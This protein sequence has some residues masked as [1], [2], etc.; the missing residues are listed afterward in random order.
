MQL[1]DIRIEQF[2]ALRDL[3]LDNL[4]PRLT[5]VYGPAGCGKSTFVS[6]LRGMLFGLSRQN[7]EV[8]GFGSPRSTPD[9]GSL[10]VQISMGTGM[11]RRTASLGGSETFSFHDESGRSV[12][13]ESS[14]GLSETLLPGWVTEDVFR[15]VCS[16]G[17]TEATRFDLLTRLCTALGHEGH[18]A[19][20]EVRRTETALQQAVRDRDGN[21]IQGGVVHRISELRRRQGELQGEIT[22]LRRP[23]HD[24]QLRIE[25]LVRE[26]EL[27][28]ATI[29]RMDSRLQGIDSEL[30]R[31]ERLL[32]DLQVCNV[33]PLNRHDLDSDIQNLTSRLER[34]REIRGMI[35]REAESHA[36]VMETR[37][38]V[39]DSVRSVRALIG[40]LEE[41]MQTLSDQNSA[42][43]P[44]SESLVNT[45]VLRQLKSETA[46]LCQYFGEHERQILQAADYSRMLWM[47]RCLADATQLE[48]VLESQLMSLQ[49]EAGRAGNILAAGAVPEAV[50]ECQFS[51]HH[52][53][54]LSDLLTAAGFRTI[55]DVEAELVRLRAERSRLTADRTETE[56]DRIAKRSLL[57]KLR[58]ELSA[59]GSLEQLD[60]LRAQIAEIDAEVS[61]LEDHRRHLDRA[62]SSLREVIERLKTRR[63]SHLFE[64]A[65]EYAVRLTE[66]ECVR[67]EAFGQDRLLV[68]L[69]HHAD[70]RPMYQLSRSSQDMIGL[71]LRLALLQTHRTTSGHVPLILDDYFGAVDSRT[72]V[73]AQLLQEISTQGQQILVVTSRTAVKDLFAGLH[74]DVRMFPVRAE[75]V[76]QVMAPPQI[77]QTQPVMVKLET[78]PMPPEPEREEV[79]SLEPVMVPSVTNWLF[80]LEVDHG[81]EDLAGITLGELEGLRSAGVLTVND[82]LCRTV[83]QLEELVRHKGFLIS[84]DRLQAL[85]GQAELA[86]RV[87]MLRRSDASLL[88]ASGIRSA[89]ELSRLRPE[90][91][92]DRVTAFQRTDAGTRFRRGGRLIDRQQAINWARFGQFTRTLEDA[93]HSRSRFGV[94]AKPRLL[95]ATGLESISSQSLS[96]DESAEDNSGRKRRR[97]RLSGDGSSEDRRA[98]RQARRR[99]QVSRLRADT[100]T[101]GA[102][103]GI[104]VER[105]GGMRFFLSRSSEVEKAPSIGPR[106]ARMLEAIGIRTVEELLSIS[107]DRVAEK[108]NHRRITAE[109]IRQWQSQASL[110]CQIPELRGHDAQILV[111]CGISTPEVLAS[112]DANELFAVVEPFARTKEGERILRS[113]SQPDLA[114]VT[115]WIQWAANARTLRAA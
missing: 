22:Q 95:A 2:G 63:W 108:L 109:V 15:E 94:R 93:Q 41:R 71:A 91:V 114:E 40:R 32:A 8:P 5:V 103:E 58:L 77:P 65:S 87:P 21:G 79:V 1:T 39:H 90:T 61:L 62:E 80:Y 24:L 9:S 102:D 55:E 75:A 78:P 105:V 99:Q 96:T 115:E 28:T 112:H 106:T 89:E 104:P 36:L 43:L 67:I 29:A 14:R 101:D 73:A 82:L 84:V 76:T 16:P 25:Q 100:P 13:D 56:Q 57:E 47:E 19:E 3:A 45:E 66:G 98:R 64:V 4:S 86:V 33:L 17:A 31:L 69:R 52:Q 81:M 27:A 42:T 38:T 49:T 11:V 6:F 30:V 12:V 92:Y 26:I 59:G 110:L 44:H 111:A 50:L 7:R 34:W 83:P 10:R 46:A 60:V 97:R 48:S 35:A 53:S 54:R 23:T 74:T 37:L 18:V 68:Q 72:V 20:V 113:G 70:L 85:R 88:F 107:P 51:G